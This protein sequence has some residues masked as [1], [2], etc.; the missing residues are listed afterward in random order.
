MGADNAR[1]FLQMGM[2]RAA[3][4]ANYKGGRK[5][6]NGKVKAKKDAKGKGKNVMGKE[7]GGGGEGEGEDNGEDGG[8]E[9]KE[10]EDWEGRREKREARDIFRRYWE[11]AKGSGEYQRMKEEFLARR[12]EWEREMKGDGERTEKRRKKKAK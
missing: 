4:Y 9:E 1:K 6:V 10:E 7:D 8:G 2:T 11:R 5:Y 12:K 3:R